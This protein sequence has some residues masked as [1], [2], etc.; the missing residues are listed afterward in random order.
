[1]TPT[2]EVEATTEV[3]VVSLAAAEVLPASE[4]VGGAA[5][6]L[7]DSAVVLASAVVDG[8]AEDAEVSAVVLGAAEDAELA[9]AQISPVMVK[10]SVISLVVSHVVIGE[11]FHTGSIRSGAL[12][13]YT[14]GGG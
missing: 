13:Q 7:E 14:G 8:A 5:A 4:D 12:A 3:A 6:E 9:A 11:Q 2:E 1:M 10:V